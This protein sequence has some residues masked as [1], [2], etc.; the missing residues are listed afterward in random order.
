MAPK[1]GVGG[2]EGVVVDVG[3]NPQNFG[4]RMYKGTKFKKKR[5]AVSGTEGGT[6]PLQ[7]KQISSPR[8]EFTANY[9]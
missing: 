4:P 5:K 1:G 9:P 6:Y 3:E 8:D 2:G 7:Q